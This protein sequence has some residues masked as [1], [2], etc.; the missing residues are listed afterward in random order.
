M[1]LGNFMKTGLLM[2]LLVILC[3]CESTGLST[4]CDECDTVSVEGS[5]EIVY[6]R[7][8]PF[9]DPTLTHPQNQARFGDF[10]HPGRSG[11]SIDDIS[12]YAKYS[13]TLANDDTLLFV[14]VGDDGSIS[15]NSEH[16]P[17]A[18]A[19]TRRL[20]E[21]FHERELNGVFEE[22]SSRTAKA[23]G[24]R[25]PKSAEYGLLFEIAAAVRDSGAEPI[26]LL[27]DGHLPESVISK[28]NQ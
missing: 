27:L 18:I 5:T 6:V 16:Q 3:G 9:I 15:L 4:G 19:L 2:L 21:L 7:I 25:V 20:A 10:L 12:Y 17:N 11:H 24:I 13:G 8:P 26:V 28:V 23:V 22:G 14:T 1:N